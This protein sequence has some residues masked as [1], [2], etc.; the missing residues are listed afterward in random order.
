MTEPIAAFQVPPVEKSVLLPCAPA[1]AFEAFT[2]EIAQW[3]PLATHSI[4]QEKATRVTIEPRVGGRV[5]ETAAD[6]AEHDWGRVLEWT[7]PRRFAMTWH[8]GRGADTAQILELDFAAEGAGTR[9]RLTHRGWETLGD[10]ARAVRDNYESGWASILS[11]N[12]AAHLGGV[13]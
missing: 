4:G 8:P 11:R 3:W 1:R 2:A 5:Y 12:F 10:K 7:P 13:P 9:V 6:G